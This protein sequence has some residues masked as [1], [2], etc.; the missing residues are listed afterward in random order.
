MALSVVCQ[1]YSLEQI[2]NNGGQDAEEEIIRYIEQ[3][4]GKGAVE[5]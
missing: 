5:V 4:S 2:I 1:Q 3:E